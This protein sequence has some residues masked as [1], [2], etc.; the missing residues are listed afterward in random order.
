MPLS[1]WP[2]A[3][4]IVEVGPRDGLQHE[5]TSLATA[6][7]AR[8]IG[9]LAAAGLRDIEATS[10]VSPRAIPQL[11]DADALMVQLP[12]LPPDTRLSAL[13]ANARGLERAMAAGVRRIALFT[14]ASDAFTQ[15]NIGRTV[16]ESLADFAPLAREALAAGMSVR[17]YVSM[18]FVCPDAGEISPQSVLRVSEA[19]LAMGVEEV[20]LGD[21]VG[22]AAPTDVERLLACLL[23][24][25]APERL[26]LH[27]HDT[28]GTALANIV[29]ALRMGITTFDASVG[30][31]GGCPYAPG[32]AGNV[33]TEDVAYLLARM[34]VATG[35]D[36]SRLTQVARRMEAL[37]GCPLP[38]HQLRRS[39]A[40]K[41]VSRAT[42][43]DPPQR[44]L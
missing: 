33:A 14:A 44:P 19:L 23:P 38:S 6:E 2:R 25:I 28:C 10:F 42:D 13:V 27:C 18:C 30:G 21:T 15:R 41:A 22:M 11:A 1:D 4:R 34:G 39:L 37:L 9:E 20:S 31:L 36:G 26:A 16:A 8:L 29:S 40:P 7:K 12:P 17:G 3:A 35:I 24:R 32:A 43:A 5:A